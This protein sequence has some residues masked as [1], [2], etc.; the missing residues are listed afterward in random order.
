[1]RVRL[2]IETGPP[3]PEEPPD[4][5]EKGPHP[6]SR[7]AWFSGMVLGLIGFIEVVRVVLQIIP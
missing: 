1:M 3:R 7:P 6:L 5:P 2:T 4:D